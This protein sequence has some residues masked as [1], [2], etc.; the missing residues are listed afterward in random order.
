MTPAP[1]AGSP[2][3]FHLTRPTRRP[4][5]RELLADIADAIVGEP[6]PVALA[7][8]LSRQAG[9]PAH[10]P[11]AVRMIRPARL[12]SFGDVEFKSYPCRESG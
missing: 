4:V 6:A 7:A 11:I 2:S 1:A 5:P 8:P 3:S 9:P 12:G 10:N